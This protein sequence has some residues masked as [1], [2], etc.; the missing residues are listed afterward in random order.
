MRNRIYGTQA[1]LATLSSRGRQKILEHS[2]HAVPLDAPG[3]IVSAVQTVLAEIRGVE[4]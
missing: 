3:E 4:P 2:S 1:K